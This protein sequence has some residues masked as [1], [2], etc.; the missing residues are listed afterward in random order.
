MT[1][2]IRSYSLWLMVIITLA[3]CAPS[4]SNH[5]QPPATALPVTST[6]H[7]T[8]THLLATVTPTT[9]PR[10]SETSTYTPQVSPALQDTSFVFIGET[11]PDGT[12]M[13]PGQS[14]KKTWTL[15]NGGSFAWDKGMVL[16]RTSSSPANEAL[17]SPEQIPLSKEVEPGAT[18]QI[19]VDLVAPKQNGQFTVFY[20]LQNKTG[21]P[22][23]NSEIWVAITVGNVP[24]SESG[25]VAAQLVSSSMQNGEFTV[26]FCMQVPDG[27]QWYPWGVTLLAN[28]QRYSPTGSS[29]DPA[30]ATTANKCFSFR[31]PVSIVSGTNYELAIEKVE[32][33]PEVHQAENCAYAQRTLRAIYPGLDF[34]CSGPGSWYF[35]L[36]LPSGMTKEQADRLIMDAMSSSI[37]GPW[38]LNGNAP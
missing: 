22:V 23:P 19:E 32:L 18:I 3:G 13:Q 24:F 25:G 34:K 11:I 26:Y 37:Y 14:F 31:F 5:P 17:G 30:G 29:I 12:N 2:R 6:P 8:S 27:R 20:Q 9:T 38:I 33:P 1:L 28:Q 4:L 16:I 21:L 7:P 35:D 36:V 10:P 15:K